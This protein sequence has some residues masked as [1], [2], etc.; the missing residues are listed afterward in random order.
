M[1]ELFRAERHISRCGAMMIFSPSTSKSE[2]SSGIVGPRIEAHVV[3]SNEI[4][5]FDALLD[6]K[7]PLGKADSAEDSLGQVVCIDGQWAVL[8]VWGGWPGYH[9]GDSNKWGGCPLRFLAEQLT[10][11]VPNFPFLIQ[12]QKGTKK[13]VESMSF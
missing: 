11:V 5:C 2:H 1:G 13:N 12:P 6:D 7:H 3:K 9:L 8:F 10:L 4:R